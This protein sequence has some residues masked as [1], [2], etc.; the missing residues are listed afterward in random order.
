MTI[1]NCEEFDPESDDNIFFS[2]GKKYVLA[3]NLNV[4]RIKEQIKKQFEDIVIK[5]MDKFGV[6]GLKLKKKNH[7]RDIEEGQFSDKKAIKVI[8]SKLISKN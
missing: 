7:L 6:E 5:N 2:F 3:E 4:F 8:S 1:D